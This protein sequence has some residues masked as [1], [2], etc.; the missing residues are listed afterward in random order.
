MKRRNSFTLCRTQIRKLLD[1]KLKRLSRPSLILRS[2]P[3]RKSN[4]MEHYL[5]A[6]SK[7]MVCMCLLSR[8]DGFIKFFSESAWWILV[9]G[10][11]ES[12]PKLH[13]PNGTHNSAKLFHTCRPRSF[14]KRSLL[15]R[16]VSSSSLLSLIFFP[17]KFGEER[18][19]KI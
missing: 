6:E 14:Q 7:S 1:F 4:F 2:R 18:H 5:Y 13:T 19:L 17:I 3:L 12:K 16:M 15:W 8:S 11:T 10:E 9:K